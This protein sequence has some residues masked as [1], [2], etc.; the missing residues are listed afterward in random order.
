MLNV[1]HNNGEL[2]GTFTPRQ[3]EELLLQIPNAQTTKQ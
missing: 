2:I 1:Y 3:A